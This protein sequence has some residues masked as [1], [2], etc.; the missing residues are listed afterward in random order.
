MIAAAVPPVKEV[1]RV[2][3]VKKKSPTEEEDMTQ[4]LHPLLPDLDLPAALALLA[5]NLHQDLISPFCL[6]PSNIFS[7]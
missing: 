5:L 7:L 1:E 6:L 4:D 2:I 3:R